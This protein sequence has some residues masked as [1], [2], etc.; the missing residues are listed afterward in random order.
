[1]WRTWMVCGLL[2]LLG[3][4]SADKGTG[5]PV[6][7]AKFKKN[8]LDNDFGEFIDAHT[9]ETVRLDLQWEGGAFQGG[10]ERDFQFFVLFDS[11]SEELEKGER[12]AVGNCNGTEYNVPVDDGAVRLVET[13]GA[14]RLRGDF[15]PSEKTG[16]LQGLF[17]VQL[18]PVP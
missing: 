12:P 4:C 14:W 1:M 5:V 15:V 11:C 17:A 2:A 18:E 8:A 3:G 16:P 13:N 9:G 7:R 6:F 10:S